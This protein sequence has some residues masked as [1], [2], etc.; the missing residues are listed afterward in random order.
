MRFP[1]ELEQQIYD[2]LKDDA[3]ACIV[4][5]D[6]AYRDDGNILIHRDN[7]SQFLHRYLYR[8]LVDPKLGRNKFLP[9]TCETP[10][11]TSP[12]HREESNRAPRLR[13]ATHCPNGHEY[14]PENTLTEGHDRCL[15]CKIER[16]K[17]RQLIGAPSISEIN[18]AKTHCPQNH[19]YT[20]ENTYLSKTETGGVRR[21]CRTCGIERTKQARLNAKNPEN[22]K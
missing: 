19:E 9:Q 15:T 22:Q 11:C 10:G 17:R 1:A 13:K 8:K 16:R 3:D 2:V 14:T 20:P 5:P 21:K 18:A 7:M 6:E 12:F 4:L